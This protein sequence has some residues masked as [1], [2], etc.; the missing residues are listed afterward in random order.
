VGCHVT[1]WLA[2]WLLS[3]DLSCSVHLYAAIMTA[4]VETQVRKTAFFEPLL[5]S[6]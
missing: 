3:L 1:G 5:C 2:G 4:L 6:K